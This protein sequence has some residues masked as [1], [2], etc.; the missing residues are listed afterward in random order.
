MKKLILAMLLAAVSTS[1]MAEW[2]RI[3]VGDNG[4]DYVNYSSIRKTGNKVKMWSLKDWKTIH[5]IDGEKPY[6][7]EANQFE[8]DCYA[9]TSQILA[10][11]NYSGNMGHGD[12]TDAQ[13][14]R[15]DA[16]PISPD[17]I[18]EIKWKIAC[19]KK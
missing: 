2:T 16:L 19:G 8:Y 1:A 12:A 10:W 3:N 5:I 11:N 13:S 6:L 14:F 9:E 18:G 4:D 15:G 7:S 17:S